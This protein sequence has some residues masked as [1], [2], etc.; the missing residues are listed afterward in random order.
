[1]FQESTY[2]THLGTS[3]DYSNV[4]FIAR[5][6]TTAGSG[7]LRV[8]RES[9]AGLFRTEW[10]G[11]ADLSTGY[12]AEN[13]PTNHVA[14]V[15]D[16]YLKAGQPY[17][18]RDYH[19]EFPF[20]VLNTGLYLMNRELLD[21][22]REK[23]NAAAFSDSHSSIDGGEWFSYTPTVDGFY[24]LVMTMNNTASDDYSIWHGPKISTPSNTTVTVPDEVVFGTTTFPFSNRWA[25][26]GVRPTTTSKVD[27]WL[28]S[29]DSFS[30]TW[31]TSLGTANG[32][33]FI[34][35]DFRH[36]PTDPV[37]Q[38]YRRTT[39]SGALEIEHAVGFDTLP[40]TPGTVQ[41][42]EHAWASGNVVRPFDVF[43]DG[44]AAPQTFQLDVIDLTGNL[45]LGAALM[46]S[47]GAPYRGGMDDAVA[48]DKATRVGGTV[49]FTFT[50]T[51]ADWYGVIVFN[52]NAAAGDYRLQMSDGTPVSSPVADLRPTELALS[53]HV[54]PFRLGTSVSL[55][56]PEPGAARVSVYDV[57]GRLVRTL[58]DGEFAAGVHRIAW[59][60]Q[61][62][63]GRSVGA[64]VYLVRLEA[65][66]ESRTLK[67]V[68]IP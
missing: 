59:D 36:T 53:A 32:V 2:Q 43:I 33:N 41:T 63:S 51:K 52:Q 58:S 18:F 44:S 17:F 11:G 45:Q 22:V 67:L 34:A 16:V 25:V 60:G 9:G 13:W 8:I 68:R 31:D 40:F 55:A 27:M 28:M 19:F 6:H 66:A 26:W 1:M 24:G 38:R 56:M 20:P 3:D 30:A 50:A 5:D 54:N 35:V 21:T 47:N 46:E 15:W 49:S 10:E 61:D 65:N 14:K 23:V 48:I 57:Q 64:G 29:D 62:G 42:Q 39:G 7:Y 12:V 37:Y 4:E